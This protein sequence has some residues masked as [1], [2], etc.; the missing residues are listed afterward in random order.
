MKIDSVN[1]GF[2]KS[3]SAVVEQRP[4]PESEPVVLVLSSQN[5]Q[6]A[7]PQLDPPAPDLLAM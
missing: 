5:L 2:E 3:E 4:A 7:E 6:V 1:P